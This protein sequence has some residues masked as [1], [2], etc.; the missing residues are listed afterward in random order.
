MNT[1]VTRRVVAFWHLVTKGR[2]KLHS[3]KMKRD[4][5]TQTFK[6][7]TCELLLLPVCL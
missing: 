2:L 7:A 5:V 3:Q 6:V 1:D 4:A